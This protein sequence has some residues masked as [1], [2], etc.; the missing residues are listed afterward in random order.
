[1]RCIGALWLVSRNHEKIPNDLSEVCDWLFGIAVSSTDEIVPL[2]IKR[3][4]FILD[5]DRI[6]RKQ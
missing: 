1:M 3:T 2:V 6:I 4:G 5:S